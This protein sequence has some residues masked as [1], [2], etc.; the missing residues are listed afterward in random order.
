MAMSV[1][2]DLV[3]RRNPTAGNRAAERRSSHGRLS[4]S[5]MALVLTFVGCSKVSK[6]ATSPKPT[7]DSGAQ[8]VIRYYTS[9]SEYPQR[10]PI[11]QLFNSGTAVRPESVYQVDTRSDIVLGFD[12]RI[13]DVGGNIS[14]RARLLRDPP[15]E[16]PVENYTTVSDKELKKESVLLLPSNGNLFRDGKYH[17]EI[18]SSL[19]AI[20]A[21][22]AELTANFE[23]L[24][25][26]L[27][28]FVLS[29]ATISALAILDKDKANKDASYTNILSELSVALKASDDA[30]KRLVAELQKLQVIFTD[31]F[32]DGEF[33]ADLGDKSLD[34]VGLTART[35]VN[36]LGKIVVLLSDSYAVTQSVVEDCSKQMGQAFKAQVEVELYQSAAA[37]APVTTTR[38]LKDEVVFAQPTPDNKWARIVTPDQYAG[39]YV[40]LDRDHMQ[41]AP[42][43]PG[44]FGCARSSIERFVA[45]LKRHV[46]VIEEAENELIAVESAV[47]A[48][49]TVVRTD[50]NTT[51]EKRIRDA[52]VRL[53]G[54]SIQN[55][56]IIS[57]NVTVTLRPVGF[58]SQGL[59]GTPEPTTIEERFVFRA[60][61]RG[62]STSIRPQ[63]ALIKRY[64][65]VAVGTATESPS[66]FKPAPG[67]LLNFRFRRDP[68]YTE[69][70]YPSFG[71]ATFSVDFD[72][73]KTFEIGFGPSIGILNDYLHFGMGWNL[74]AD[75]HDTY[76]FLSLDFLKTSETFGTLF[77]GGGK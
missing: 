19:T 75:V 11:R 56:D 36:A 35:R 44:L 77:G 69:W 29:T 33:V 23:R 59:G 47:A 43:Q 17:K 38:V 40:K 52:R 16:L 12:K 18:Q 49:Q 66:N 46:T 72:P 64:S 68:L 5:L 32:L 45:Q 63:F 62:W 54:L 41:P 30:R 51:L 42:R 58:S 74:S 21:L 6:V 20:P 65:D 48:M 14:V 31:R 22:S 13:K 3:V 50:I 7:D 39:Y 2:P 27:G 76:Y 70:L 73:R 60:I 1:R 61:Q 55:G 8:D 10:D 67:V 26:L 71:L 28:G 53:A 24:V 25:P 4:T 15:V 37:D 9:V 34:T 57:V